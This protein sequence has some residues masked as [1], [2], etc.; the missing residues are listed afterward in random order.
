M[1]AGWRETKSDS[2]VPWGLE[3]WSAV[4]T[5]VSRRKG[6]KQSPDLRER[7]ASGEATWQ[8]LWPSGKGCSQLLII[9]QKSAA[10]GTP[11]TFSYPLTT[12][13]SLTET[14]QKPEAKEASALLYPGK[15]RV[16]KS[17]EWIWGA[18]GFWKLPVRLM[19]GLINVQTLRIQQ[20]CKHIQNIYFHAVSF[21]FA[22]TYLVSLHAPPK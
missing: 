15:H 3:Q 10:E 8:E 2:M 9:A 12:C 16:W 20:P 6:E 1:P 22:P 4:I 14:N 5:L 19:N 18:N 7:G 13:S 21:F 11:I 17:R